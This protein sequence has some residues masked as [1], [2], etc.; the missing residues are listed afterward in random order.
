MTFLTL[1]GGGLYRCSMDTP[2]ASIPWFASNEKD[3]LQVLQNATCHRHDINMTEIPFY[4]KTFGLTSSFF[5][6]F[7]IS[8]YRWFRF[9]YYSTFIS[10]VIVIVQILNMGPTRIL[11]KNFWTN[12]LGLFLALISISISMWT[13]AFGL[14]EGDIILEVVLDAFNVCEISQ[15]KKFDHSL[16]FFMK[17]ISLNFTLHFY[18]LV[19]ILF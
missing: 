14:G 12:K 17:I 7:Y 19:S 13:K 16:Q 11:S 10:C 1:G 5:G 15:G 4:N 9:T 2:G 18:R 8:S 6:L 3:L